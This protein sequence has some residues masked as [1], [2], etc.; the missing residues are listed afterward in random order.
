ML[1]R[2][3]TG[4]CKRQQRRIG[5]MVTM[6]QKAGLMT[7]TTPSFADKYAKKRFNKYY[8]EETIKVPFYMK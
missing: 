7:R 6:A 3:V 5:T 4:L 8:F 2:R 1:P